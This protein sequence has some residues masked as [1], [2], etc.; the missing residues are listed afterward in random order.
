MVVGGWVKLE[1]EG[2]WLKGRW[3]G[4]ILKRKFKFE[5]TKRMSS[6]F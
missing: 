4:T 3:T 5:I 2:R 1:E 6:M